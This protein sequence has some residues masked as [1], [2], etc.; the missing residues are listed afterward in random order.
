MN[1][2]TLSSSDPFS[3]DGQIVASTMVTDGVCATVF[4]GLENG[5]VMASQIQGD[6]EKHSTIQF[7]QRFPVSSISVDKYS[8]SVLH[9][10]H[11]N[12]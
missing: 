3:L 4:S 7:H 2:L 6:E 10:N 9:V 1:R 8:S 12:S 5:T 11:I